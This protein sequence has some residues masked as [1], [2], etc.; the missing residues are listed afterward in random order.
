[1]NKKK[2]YDATKRNNAYVRL[3]MRLFLVGYVIYMAVKMILTALAGKTT[4]PLWISWAFAVL[5]VT[6]SAALIV[7]AVRCLK[8]DIAA[9][10]IKPEDGEK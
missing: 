5:F 7:Y 1:M 4:M 9:A 2:S 6:A 10:E 8:A 3:S